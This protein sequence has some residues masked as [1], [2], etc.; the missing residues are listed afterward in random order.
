MFERFFLLVAVFIGICAA[1]ATFCNK[2]EVLQHTNDPEN[3]TSVCVS[4]STVEQSDVF[5]KCCPLNYAYDK[6][7]HSCKYQ[8]YSRH[9]R[10]FSYFDIGLRSC[11]SAAVVDHVADAKDLEVGNGSAVLK[12]RHRFARGDYCLDELYSA[13]SIVLR[14]CTKGVEGCGRDG[15]RC[16]RKCCPDLEIYVNGANCQPSVDRVFEY[17]N[18]SRGAGSGDGE[19]HW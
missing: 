11:V 19:S 6:S 3:S 16:V 17:R 2:T 14:S 1:S 15:M 18:F 8:E 10:N 4:A 9:F 7:T 5:P 12:G 13:D